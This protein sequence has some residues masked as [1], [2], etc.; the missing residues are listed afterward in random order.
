MLPMTPTPRILVVEAETIEAM[1]H[2]TALRRLGYN[3]VGSVGTRLGAIAA[4]RSMKPDLILMDIRLEAPKDG[5]DAVTTIRRE[6]SIPIVFLTTRSGADALERSGVA[7]S[8]EY[9]VKPFTELELH[10]SVEIALERA[11]DGPGIR[12]LTLSSVWQGEERSALQQLAGKIGHDF[13]NMLMVI[14]ARC[15]LLLRTVESEKQRQYVNDIRTAARKSQEMAQQLLDA[16]RPPDPG[17]RE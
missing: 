3:V 4:A 8:H 15:D 11:A 16:S 17:R 13:N 1:D 9:L 6:N 2:A 14:F 5:V 12:D 10:R 7:A